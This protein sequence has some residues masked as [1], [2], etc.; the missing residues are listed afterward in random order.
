MPTSQNK[1]PLEK[2]IL[3]QRRMRI[4][5]KAHSQYRARHRCDGGAVK[6]HAQ[7][8]EVQPPTDGA[9]A[10]ARE[11]AIPYEYESGKRARARRKEML[12]E[13]SLPNG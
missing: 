7:R 6:D 8:G 9:P 3:T 4:I 2:N 12:T 13:E 5:P 1:R 11:P 10:R